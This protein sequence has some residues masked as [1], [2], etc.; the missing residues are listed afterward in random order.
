MEFHYPQTPK[1]TTTLL[2]KPSS[3]AVAGGTSFIGEPRAK[4][5]VDLTGLGLDYIEDK[6]TKI[7]IGATTPVADLVESHALGRLASGILHSAASTLADTS[8]RNMITVGGNIACRFNWADLPPAL[9]VLS[10]KLRVTGDRKREIPVEKF[11]ESRLKPGE[12]ISEIIIPK[13]S[14]KGKGAFIK[15][16]RTKFDYSLITVATYAEQQGKK[17]SVIRVAISGVSHPTRVKAVEKE[18]QG[19]AVT[20]EL[21]EKTAPQAIK[22]IPIEKSYIF[23]ENYRREV[24]GVLLKRGLMKV[25]MEG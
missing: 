14:N 13:K 6:K 12:F 7:I 22:E 17:T 8:L 21:L 2:K 10:A 25:L 16:S 18:L 4:H 3:L 20:E 15:F 1:E 24:L 11:F 5:L 19:K 23:S 9:M